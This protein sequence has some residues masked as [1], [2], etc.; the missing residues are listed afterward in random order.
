MASPTDLEEKKVALEDLVLQRWQ[1]IKSE[2]IGIKGI[3]KRACQHSYMRVEV[4]ELVEFQVRKTELRGPSGE[5]SVCKRSDEFIIDSLFHEYVRQGVVGKE[6]E[7]D[8]HLEKNMEDPIRGCIA[9]E[10]SRYKGDKGKECECEPDTQRTEL[11]RE[12]VKKFAEKVEGP[13]GPIGKFCPLE[14]LIRE[15]V[16][17]HL[18]DTKKGPMGK[19]APCVKV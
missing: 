13:P 10:L 9:L 3:P 4:H 5:T 6:G 19:A 11:F 8:C 2:F 15:V 16:A 17:D 14:R 12:V 1:T 7:G 18:R